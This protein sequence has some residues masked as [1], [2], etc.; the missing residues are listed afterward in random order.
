VLQHLPRDTA[1]VTPAEREQIIR[2]RR[3]AAQ[4]RPHW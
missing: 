3:A 2:T 4:Q 1:L